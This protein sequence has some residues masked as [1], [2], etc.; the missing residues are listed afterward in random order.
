MKHLSHTYADKLLSMV[1]NEKT[2]VSTAAMLERYMCLESARS[3]L[4][5][6]GSHFLKCMIWGMLNNLFFNS[7]PSSAKGDT[8]L[9]MLSFGSPKG[10]FVESLVPKVVLLEGGGI[11]E[12]WDLVGGH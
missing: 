11:F 6:K 7:V 3:G 5:L 2:L 12:R 4:I 8:I 1:S 9:R 10:P